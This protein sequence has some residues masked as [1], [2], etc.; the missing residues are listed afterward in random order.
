MTRKHFLFLFALWIVCSIGAAGTAQPSSSVWPARPNEPFAHTFS[1]VARDSASGAIG[2]AVQ[3]HWFSVG[4]VVCWAEAGVG[5]VATQS[6]VNKSFGPRGLALMAAGLSPEAALDSLLSDDAARSVRQVALLDARGRV[7]VHTGKDCI[8]YACHA[9]GMQYAVQANMMLG[10]D[11]CA[12]M[13]QALETSRQKPL[14]ERLLL[15][16]EAAQAAGG[17]FR[18]QQSAALLVVRSQRSERPWED[19]LIDLRVDDHP[20]AVAELRRLYTVHL[21]YE[22]MNR[23]DHF[24]ELR[25]MAAAM[26]EYEA[27]HQILPQKVELQFWTA[28]TLAN[29]GQIE[30]ALPLFAAVFR[31]EPVW[32][33]ALHRIRSAGLLTASDAEM[34]RILQQ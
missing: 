18:G 13:Q 1:V 14:A 4:T 33:I 26:R 29:T 23:G 10:P 24:V 8:A 19:R 20:E 32:K 5:A 28:V 34:E 15:A 6:F 12:A 27:A 9:T 3:S 17:D 11:V 30:A 2:V 16:L 25:D 31:Q 7:A 21:A 22:H